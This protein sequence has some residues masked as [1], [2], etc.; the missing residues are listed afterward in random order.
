MNKLFQSYLLEAFFN[1]FKM[2]YDTSLDI[3]WTLN[4]IIIDLQL[5]PNVSCYNFVSQRC[6]QIVYHGLFSAPFSF[7]KWE[8]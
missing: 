8:I 4:K 7:S 1:S 6:I 2:A 5:Y 3:E